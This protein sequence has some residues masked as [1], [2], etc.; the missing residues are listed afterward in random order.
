MELFI[1]SLTM[2]S[3]HKSSMTFPVV[4]AADS[5]AFACPNAIH[6]CVKL[7]SVPF[8]MDGL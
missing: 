8:N 5:L 2:L 4:D 3:S 7:L 1:T 6:I